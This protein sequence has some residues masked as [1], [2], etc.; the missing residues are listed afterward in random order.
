M[1]TVATSLRKDGAMTTLPEPVPLETGTAQE[2]NEAELIADVE[3]QFEELEVSMDMSPL[4]HP[5]RVVLVHAHP[6]DETTNTGTTMASLVARGD[7][8]TLV[9]CTRGE[10]GDVVDP[11]QV[12]LLSTGPD[13][14]RLGE[15]RMGE[16]AAAMEA[17][18]VTDHRWLGGPGRWR[19]SGMMGEPSNDDPRC[20]WQADLAGPTAE[21]VDILREIRPQV[22]ITYDSNGNYGHPDHIQAYRVAVAGVAAAA[23]PSY[24]AAGGGEPWQ[25]GR[26]LATAIPRSVVLEAVEAGLMPNDNDM[27]GVPDEE[28]AIV[29]DGTEQWQA[30]LAAMRAYKTQIDLAQG[31]W[32]MLTADNRF[33]RESFVLISGTGVDGVTVDDL[34]TGL[35]S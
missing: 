13:D 23:D 4:D 34:F 28:I 18:R 12:D 6:D 30:K 9:T 1:R 32:A 24:V 22:V 31:M 5:R 14:N 20:F 16:L 3:S 25:V 35:P 29:I 10:L 17:L 2:V 8:V 33:A 11:T 26:L 27:T 15:H 7:L 21:L 19:D